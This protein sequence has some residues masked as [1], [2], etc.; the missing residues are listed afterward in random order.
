MSV[1][2]AVILFVAIVALG[3][4]AQPV[5]ARLRLPASV[6]LASVGILIGFASQYSISHPGALLP[7]EFAHTITN[8][9]VGSSLFLYLFLPTLIFESALQIDIHRVRE[10]LL[11]ILILAL[12]AVVVATFGVAYALSPFT[13]M[14]LLA[15]LIL[16]AL[17]A[18]TDP[19]AVIG[20]FKD[21]GA[22]ERLTRLVEGESLFND[23]A[24][25]SLF[26]VFTGALVDPSAFRVSNALLSFIVMPLGGAALGFV[27][28]WALLFVL[29]FVPDDRLTAVSLSLAVPFIAFWAAEHEFHVSGIIALVVSG[30]TLA[31]LAPGRLTPE[32]WRYL[33]DIWQQLAAWSAV[34][35]FFMT[36]LL[37][38][39]LIAGAQWADFGLLLILFAAA[40]TARALILWGVF[41]LLARL[42]LTPR[43]TVPFRVVTLWGG[44]R[45]SMTLALALAVTENEA[46]PPAVSAFVA[47][48]ATGYT[49]MTLFLQ[50][51]SLRWIIQRL[52]LTELTGV[53]RAIR[54]VAL[55]ATAARVSALAN[56]MAA[57]FGAKSGEEGA[58]PDAAGD[59][60][61]AA[62]EAE[63]NAEILGAEDKTAL[64]L[65]SLTAR[66]RDLIL[67]HF[68]QRT[69]TP[70]IARWLVSDARRRLDAVRA[71]G[72]AGYRDATEDEA[73]F[74]WPDRLAVTMQRRFGYQRF[75]GRRLSSRFQKL[76]ETA[77]VL[78][79]LLEFSDAG[80]RPILGEEAA[81]AARTLVSE[82]R[83]RIDREIV[84]VRL[85]Y[86][87]YVRE[88]ERWIIDRSL[89]ALE[90]AEIAEMRATGLINQEVER[91][92]L[93]GLN[94]RRGDALR[95]PDLDL[96]VDSRALLDQCALFDPLS[97]S[98]KAGLAKL[99]RPSFEVPGIPIIIRGERGTEAY[100]ISSGAVEIDTGSGRHRLGRGDFFG[101]MALLFDLRRTATVSAIA[102][103]TMLRLSKVDFD[104]FLANHPKLKA[105]MEEI[106]RSRL[107]ENARTNAVAA[108]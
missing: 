38:P 86:P 69:V 36:A 76:M 7:E 80:L 70:H 78:D 10:D 60:A 96:D 47:T 50:G 67:T 99:L 9:P 64:A 95:S 87:K 48:L 59:A 98:D 39:K 62:A 44:L 30:V 4:L 20:I 1:S 79:D 93:K 53:D 72:V 18:T 33:Q 24:A 85:Q 81:E 65:I 49:L 55:D 26:L 3:A 40:T 77:L 66:E 32:I 19:V 83:E 84:A 34:L 94:V 15:C 104:A 103:S 91:D 6:V 2:T 57:R 41:P 61:D 5:A 17:V 88:L 29:K 58:Q 107:D 45:G 13:A 35:I 43:L 12:V 27:M 16:A 89:H 51:T 82:R 31:S 22:P 74:T 14:P 28:A 100:F 11:P 90:L 46:I 101:E 92:A 52:G 23:A 68:A 105:R 97:E 54:D 42:D 8:L 102:Y 37:V 21:V 71:S 75:L 56:D 106:G 73:A 63:A 25:I 108:E